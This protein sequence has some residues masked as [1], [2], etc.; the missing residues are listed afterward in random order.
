VL[1]KWEEQ[2]PASPAVPAEERKLRL[3]PV[4][5]QQISLRAIDP[6]RLVDEDHPVRAIWDSRGRLDL[7]PFYVGIEAVEG[8]PGRDCSAPWVLIALG[9]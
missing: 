7:R 4:D 6:E 5:R 2:P 8:H 1:V 3:K 9:L